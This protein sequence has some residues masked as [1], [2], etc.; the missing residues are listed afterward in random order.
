[1]SS[2]RYVFVLCVCTLLQLLLLPSSIALCPK[3]SIR[4]SQQRRHGTA[5]SSSTVPRASIVEDAP[6]VS[7]EEWLAARG[8]DCGGCEVSSFAGGLRGLAAARD[9]PP[10]TVL[11]RVPLSACLLT[12]NFD[13]AAFEGAAPS[14]TKGLPN[15]VQLAVQAL[16][17]SDDPS[18]SYGSFLSSWPDGVPSLNIPRDELLREAQSDALVEQIDSHSAWVEGQFDAATKAAPRS[19]SFS[20]DEF[21]RALQL[22]GSRS[23]AVLRSSG[24]SGSALVPLLDMANHRPE[25]N[26]FHR[27][28]RAGGDDGNAEGEGEAIELVSRATISEGEEISISYG[29][30]PNDV[31]AGCYGFVPGDNP[32]AFE[33]ASLSQI[34]R[35]AREAGALDLSEEDMDIME[36]IMEVS[37]AALGFDARSE[38]RILATGPEEGLWLCLRAALSGGEK[39]RELL[40]IIEAIDMD[41]ADDEDLWESD[42]HN[43]I[44]RRAG[45]L[46]A[47]LGA[48]ERNV[49]SR[50]TLEEDEELLRGDNLSVGKRLLVELRSERKRLLRSASRKMAA[51]AENPGEACRILFS[52]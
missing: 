38:F 47:A 14:W 32:H 33:G 23:L 9:A 43:D 5:R 46:R 34:L 39:R 30:Y 10:G 21:A 45:I 20:F 22:A 48:L 6:H 2:E 35:A 52:R 42:D 15:K 7:L 41:E 1:M 40:D 16:R 12:A 24:E 8:I 3:S 25:P 28:V 29:E 18:S 17:H 4:L 49:S 44:A 19:C 51:V 26:A 13:E 36:G 37:A 27:Y 31:L 11:L 50:S